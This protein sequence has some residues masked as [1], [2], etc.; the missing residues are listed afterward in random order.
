MAHSREVR[1]PLLDH[2]LVEFLFS[3]PPS[4]KIHKGWTK[5]LL[6][7]ALSNLLPSEITWRTDKIGYEP[8]QKKWQQAQKVIDSTQASFDL[9]KQNYLLFSRSFHSSSK[10]QS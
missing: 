6:R 2:E 4:F 10:T 5:F 9:L 7:D 8:P 1:L 3:L